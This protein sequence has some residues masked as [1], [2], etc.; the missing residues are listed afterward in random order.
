MNNTKPDGNVYVIGVFVG[1]L[2]GMFVMYMNYVKHNLL[3][4]ENKYTCVGAE[5]L[6]EDPSIVACTILL[7]KDSEAHKKFLEMNNDGSV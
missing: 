6:G 1:F 4:P 3:L 5:P 2:M 7:R